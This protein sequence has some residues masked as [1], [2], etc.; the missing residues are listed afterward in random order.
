MNVQAI[1][2]TD[3]TNFSG[4]KLNKSMTNTLYAA[5]LSA[6]MLATG[7]DVFT[8]SD[9]ESN[10]KI[11]EKTELYV[12]V[13]EQTQKAQLPW[14]NSQFK[15]YVNRSIGQKDDSNWATWLLFIGAGVAYA[16]YRK[17]SEN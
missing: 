13:E 16:L 4:L 10:D 15:A 7:M 17:F 8:K 5:A 6:S 3:Q 14:N 9:K 2:N 1:K 12:P 11:Q